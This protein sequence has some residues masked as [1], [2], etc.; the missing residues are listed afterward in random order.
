MMCMDWTNNIILVFFITGMGISLDFTFCFSDIILYTSNPV[1]SSINMLCIFPDGKK[2]QNYLLL[3][4]LF[5][6]VLMPQ[7]QNKFC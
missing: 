5:H 4:L 7:T 6:L 3:E 2:L 1:Q